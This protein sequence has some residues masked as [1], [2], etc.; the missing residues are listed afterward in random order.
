MCMDMRSTISFN[1]IHFVV[2]I[3]AFADVFGF[4]NI[5]RGM[6]GRTTSLG[7]GFLGKDVI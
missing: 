6:I 7:F 1:A 4:S 2:I 3:K 5:D